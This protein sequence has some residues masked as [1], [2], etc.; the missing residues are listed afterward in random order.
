MWIFAGFLRVI[1]LRL[2]K[3][4]RYFFTLNTPFLTVLS[5]WFYLQTWRP[6]DR[7]SRSIYARPFPRE[8]YRFCIHFTLIRLHNSN[9]KRPEFCQKSFEVPRIDNLIT[10]CSIFSLSDKLGHLLPIE[11]M[12]DLSPAVSFFEE[13]GNYFW[14]NF[15]AWKPCKIDSTATNFLLHIYW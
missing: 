6:R 2:L 12:R 9:V 14:S 15:F 1:P 11:R 5:T 4:P 10:F 7:S 13:V 8:I 3:N